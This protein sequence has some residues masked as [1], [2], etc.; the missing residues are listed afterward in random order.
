[1]RILIY[2]RTHDGDPNQNGCFGAYDCMGSVRNYRYDAVIGI[3]GIGHEAIASGISGKI[4]WIGI[5]PH[6]S[7]VHGKRGPEITFDHFLDFGKDGPASS[8]LTPTIAQRMYSLN[9]RYTI[10]DPSDEA[11]DEVCQIVSVA[12][13][14]PPSGKFGNPQVKKRSLQKCKAL[15]RNECRYAKKAKC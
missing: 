12:E 14:A 8:K 3:G 2:K 4:N 5:G 1:M 9:V 6:K 15:S 11:Y 10:V 7:F 13:N